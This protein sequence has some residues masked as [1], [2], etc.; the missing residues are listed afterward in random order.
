MRVRVYIDGLNLFYGALQH[1]PH[2][3][4]DLVKLARELKPK[5]SDLD[6]VRYFTAAVTGESAKRQNVYLRALETLSLVSI[7][8]GTFYHNVD[9]RPLSATPAPGMSAPIEGREGGGTWKALP[10]PLPGGDVRVSVENHEEKGSDVN[11]ATYLMFDAL[12]DKIDLAIVLTGDSDLAEPVRLCNVKCGKRVDI[13]NP[14]AKH[15]ANL[16]R[17]VAHSYRALDPSILSRCHLPKSMMAK[18]KHRIMCPDAWL[19]PPKQTKGR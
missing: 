3:W 9:R 1:S 8:R 19:E 12:S 11:L 18:N 15:Q 6:M 13:V 4:L 7:H 14:H 2:R 5:D 17:E 16:L 10:D